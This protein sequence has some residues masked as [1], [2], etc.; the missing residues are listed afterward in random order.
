[1]P[2]DSTDKSILQNAISQYITLETA[3]DIGDHKCYA[4]IDGL[5]YQHNSVMCSA[6]EFVSGMAHTN[7]T[8]SARTA[9]KRGHNGVYHN[10][11]RQHLHQYINKFVF[12]LN[13]GVCH[14][15]T[16]NRLDSLFKRMAG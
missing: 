8:E 2:I 1:M 15:D 11:S 12:R 4:N 10:W 3:L 13:D 6:K 7:G 9:L 14:R 5:L 16:Q